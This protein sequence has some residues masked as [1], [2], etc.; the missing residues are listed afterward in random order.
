MVE[1]NTISILLALNDSGGV[2]KEALES[3][4]FRIVGVEQDGLKAIAEIAYQHPDVV[5]CDIFLK[6]IDAMGLTEQ[7][8][9]K[10]YDGVIIGLSDSPADPFA[11]R[12]MYCGADYFLV[13]P[14]SFEY[15][16]ERIR[17][18][19]ATGRK[20]KKLPPCP[21]QISDEFDLEQYVSDMMHQ[22]GVPA[23]IRGYRYIRSSIIMAL[24][25][26][27][28]LNA[29]TKELYPGVA[30]E[31]GTTP[32]RVERAI[33]HA[34]EVAW[35]RGDIEALN[36]MFGYTIKTSKGKPTNGEFISMLTD[37]LRMTLKIG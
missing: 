16:A 19:H 23:H 18:L 12:M 36:A 17:M 1:T 30:K 8:R 25:N 2:E 4:G 14:F 33:R 32:S 31:Y 35:T 3:L 26:S 34:I 10:G 20:K 5:I 21:P 9:A 6:Q 15:L 29:I 13:R 11:T 24:G 37:R 28:L 7:L 27:S 22:I